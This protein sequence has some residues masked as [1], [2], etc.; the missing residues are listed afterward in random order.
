MGE[1]LN[2]TRRHMLSPTIT[3]MKKMNVQLTSCLLVLLS[4]GVS[5]KLSH[6]YYPK[7]PQNNNK[8]QVQ[9]NGGCLTRTENFGRCWG[10]KRHHC[11]QC[12][13]SVC[14]QCAQQIVQTKNNG[15]TWWCKP[16]INDFRK[17]WGTEQILCPCES[18]KDK[19]RVN[20]EH[21]RK[22]DARRLE[23][24]KRKEMLRKQRQK[25][26]EARQLQEQQRLQQQK[27]EQKRRE[28][29]L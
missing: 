5:G 22:I 3:M 18:C 25:R 28:E 7:G 24:T 11:R 17:I 6:W 23:I 13:K 21:R 12:A 15:T 16:C 4:V 19:D 1:N 29:E 20:L 2:S 9:H 14:E 27:E 8:C 10:P 26:E